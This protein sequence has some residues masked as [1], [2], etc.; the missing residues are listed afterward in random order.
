M[1][2]THGEGRDLLM[3][4]KKDEEARIKKKG[5]PPHTRKDLRN[6]LS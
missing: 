4:K 1:K 5:G 2:T 6:P 3:G